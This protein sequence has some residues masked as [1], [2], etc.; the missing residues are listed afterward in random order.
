MKIKYKFLLSILS[1][2][3]IFGIILN[4][5]IRYILIWQM[6]STITNSLNHIMYSSREAIKYRLDSDEIMV[7]EDNL[8]SQ[9]DYLSRYISA[10]FQCTIEMRGLDGKIITDNTEVFF[11]ETLD[12]GTL[13]A[14]DGAAVINLKYKDKELYGILS[15]P[16]F[17]NKE[18]QGILNVVKDFS[19]DYKE[20][21][22][23]IF[24]ITLIEGFICVFIYL[25]T[26]ILT[27]KITKPIV[28]LTEAVKEVGEGDYSFFIDVNGKDELSIL[29]R[30]F[31]GMKD[32]I[33]DQIETIKEEKEKVET[34]LKGRKSFFDNV[35]HEMKTPLTAISGYAEMIM[36]DMVQDE[37]FN[38]RAV[39]RIYLESERLHGLIIDLIKVSKGLS[40]T[41]E[42]VMPI[43]MKVLI[44]ETCDDMRSKAKKNSLSIINSVESGYIFGQ[45]NRIRELVINI[46]DNGIKYSRN[47]G[48]VRVIGK[49]QDNEYVFIV[50]SMS[51][52]IPEEVYANIFE[53]FI[54][55]NKFNEEESRGLG[56]YICNEIIKEHEG[57]IN[58]TNGEKVIVETRILLYENEYGNNLETI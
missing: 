52:Y 33:K 2:V 11:K 39:E 10:N 17:I 28:A 27:T 57:V 48:E 38:K 26:Y 50:E 4:I 55:S 7:G 43:D 19:D 29:L 18:K 36:E 53:P 24:F 3:L 12:K 41:K 8:D 30:E 25:Y 37:E 58:V 23:M 44:D 40:Y 31:I 6:E 16:I 21:N 5:A 45:V 20:S 15:Y 1:I 14:E 13:S 46:M 49:V 35:T 47:N 54:K 32:K 42:E 51:G 56:L 22:K 34:L 9:G